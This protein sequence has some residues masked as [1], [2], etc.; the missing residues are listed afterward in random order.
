MFGNAGVGSA[1]KDS[2]WD[3]FH[4]L[5]GLLMGSFCFSFFKFAGAEALVFPGI[6]IHVQVSVEGVSLLLEAEPGREDL[7]LG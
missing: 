1:F 2:G 6:S 5:Q 7:L 4:A 3:H